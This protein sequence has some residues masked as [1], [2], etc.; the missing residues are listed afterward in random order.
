MSVMKIEPDEFDCI[1]CGRHIIR[2]ISEL[3]TPKL[4]AMCM[5]LP[6]WFNDPLLVHITHNEDAINPPEHEKR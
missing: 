1:E 5:H 4:C 3:N 6:G 2:I